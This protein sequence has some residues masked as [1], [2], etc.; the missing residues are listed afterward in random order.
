MFVNRK[1]KD[2]KW[3]LLC[4]ALLLPLTLSAA[5][6]AAPSAVLGADDNGPLK[7]GQDVQQ[8]KLVDQVKPV[9]PPL[10]K[11][12]KAEGAVMLQVTVARDGSVAKADVI[13]GHALLTRA[14]ADA[15]KQWKYRPTVVNGQPVEVV[16]TVRIAFTL[17]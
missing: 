15:V 3:S 9:Y 6:P 10:A 2:R 7:V 13:S 5:T 16:T 14:A 1:T 11:L 4:G 8:L 12:S 17:K